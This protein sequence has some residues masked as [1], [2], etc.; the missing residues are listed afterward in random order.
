MDPPLLIPHLESA[1]LSMQFVE[2]S[3]RKR[4]KL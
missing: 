4:A 1:T 2:D 3:P